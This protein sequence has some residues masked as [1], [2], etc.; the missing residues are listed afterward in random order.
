MS[1]TTRQ[2]HDSQ[3]R[4]KARAKE[5]EMPTQTSSRTSRDWYIEAI[6]TRNLTARSPTS[7]W[8]EMGKVVT[9]AKDQKEASVRRSAV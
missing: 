6:Q 5:K 1:P 9:T 8:T 3:V 7:T 4:E 2:F